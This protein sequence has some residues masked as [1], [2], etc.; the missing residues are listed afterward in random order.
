MRVVLGHTFEVKVI[1]TKEITRIM[2]HCFWYN[3]FSLKLVKETIPSE[4]NLV[5]FSYNN[6]T[7]INTQIGFSIVGD[8]V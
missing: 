5:T 1:M 7:K 3:N 4:Y 2:G 6:P 8:F